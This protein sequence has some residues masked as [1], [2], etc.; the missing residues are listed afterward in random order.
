MLFISLGIFSLALRGIKYDV[1][2]KIFTLQMKL[3]IVFFLLSLLLICIEA[4]SVAN[5][6]PET[7]F[8]KLDLDQGVSFNCVLKKILF[9]HF[10]LS[11]SGCMHYRKLKEQVIIVQR[12]YF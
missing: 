7:I 3:P 4:F 1:N 12:K 9:S 11:T 10:R 5:A 6:N 8:V 2:C